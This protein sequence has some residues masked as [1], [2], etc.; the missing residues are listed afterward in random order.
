MQKTPDTIGWFTSAP[1]STNFLQ[2]SSDGESASDLGNE[3]VSFKAIARNNRGYT[4]SVDVVFGVLQAPSGSLT[5][6]GNDFYIID[7]A[8]E[9][10]PVV[11]N[12]DGITSQTLLSA[13]YNT[14]GDPN[15][16]FGTPT[17][18]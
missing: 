16:S 17:G 1:L 13:T 14:S 9:D 10:D 8:G 7:S 18:S 5:E 11:N 4:G 6:E 2:I 12:T 3:T 15:G